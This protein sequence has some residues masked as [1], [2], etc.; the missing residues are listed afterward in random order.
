MSD[1]QP[2]PDE[3][4]NYHGGWGV[5][6]GAR[7]IFEGAEEV[8]IHDRFQVEFE[9]ATI[10]NPNHTNRF[11]LTW[12]QKAGIDRHL[13]MPEETWKTLHKTERTS[14]ERNLRHL[15]YSKF[16]HRGTTLMRKA[17]TIYP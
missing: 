11:R 7:D 12:D 9:R 10:N 17:E 3:G 16:F 14:D 4:M 6:I 13:N 2:D 5:M 15:A 8:D 1:S